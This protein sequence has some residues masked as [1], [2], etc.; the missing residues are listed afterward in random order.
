MVRD[1]EVTDE[2]G[3][4]PSQGR[5]AYYIPEYQHG[6]PRSAPLRRLMAVML[7][8][9]VLRDAADIT[10]MFVVKVALVFA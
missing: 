8:L 6:D 2:D 3:A 9:V 7:C 1:A 4:N 5:G 10:E